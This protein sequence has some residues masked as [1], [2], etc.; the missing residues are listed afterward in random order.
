MSVLVGITGAIGSGKTT[1]SDALAGVVEDHAIYETWHIIGEI[2]DSFN[3]YLAAELSYETTSNNVELINQ[4]LIWL[5][6]DITEYLH[7]DVSWAQIALNPRDMRARPELYEKLLAYVTSAKKSPKLLRQPITSENKQSYRPI[8]QWLG[9]YLVAKV[10]PTIWYDELIRR[11]ELHDATRSLI[12]VNGVRYPSDEIV[13]RKRGGIIVGIERPRHAADTKDI[14]E[15]HRDLL[16]VDT[17]IVNCGTLEGL[18]QTAETVWN[19]LAAGML[20]KEYRSC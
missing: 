14:T 2:A 3:Q 15:A 13:I 18:A 6:Q 19:D 9:G 7:H 8:L 1:F 4:A 16:K 12:V 5:P 10:S 17:T 11:I 20:K